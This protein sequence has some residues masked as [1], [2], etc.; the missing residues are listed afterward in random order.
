MFTLLGLLVLTGSAM[1]VA[2]H[3]SEAPAYKNQLTSI[4]DYLYLASGP[5][6]SAYSLSAVNTTISAIALTPF[7]ANV[8]LKIRRVLTTMRPNELLVQASASMYY[9]M[10]YIY[11]LNV[12]NATAMSVGRFFPVTS[13]PLSNPV[14]AYTSIGASEYILAIDGFSALKLMQLEGN[15]LSLLD[16][17]TTLGTASFAPYSIAV[18]GATIAIADLENG[19]VVFTIEDNSLSWS[20][21]IAVQGS[22]TTVYIA[23]DTA[24]L[25]TENGVWEYVRNAEGQFEQIEFVYPMTK[26]GWFP[27]YVVG[28]PSVVAYSQ[29]DSKDNS[30]ISVFPR[31]QTKSFLDF[32]TRFDPFLIL[33]TSL[34]TCA[35]GKLKERE[36]NLG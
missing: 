25:G 29:Y 12:A 26:T 21:T 14:L 28:T 5:A 31:L 1:R 20:Q 10:T 9:P 18:D 34:Y 8:P 27:Y 35:K 17:V 36:L 13:T 6:L 3:P 22:A 33:G 4:G 23:N 32:P 24:W 7:A 11:F 2:R 19:F 15:S 30:H 16:T